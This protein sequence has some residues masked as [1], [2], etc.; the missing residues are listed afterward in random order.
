MSTNC[1]VKFEVSD[2]RR[3]EIKEENARLGG[4]RD[5]IEQHSK[6]VNGSRTN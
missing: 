2:E 5:R 1:L 3:L 4:G 6:K